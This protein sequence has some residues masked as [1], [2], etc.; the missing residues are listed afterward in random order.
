MGE[1]LSKFST[2][3]LSL[4]PHE[5]EYLISVNKFEDAEKKSILSRIRDNSLRK[6]P[7]DIYDT[8]ID[9]RKYSYVMNWCK[10]RLAEIDVDKIFEKLIHKESQIMNDHIDAESEK[11]LLKLFRTADSSFFSFMKLYDLARI[12]RHFL[13]IRLRHNDFKIVDNFLSKYKARYEKARLTNDKLYS[14]TQSIITQYT[15]QKG[16]TRAYEKWLNSVYKDSTLDGYNRILAWIRIIFIRHNYR[17][18]GGLTTQFRLFD[19]MLKNGAF[20]SRRIIANYHSQ[21]LLYY[22]SINDVE[23]AIYNGYL[24]IREENND[25]LYY[26]NN[27]AALLLKANRVAEAYQ[28]LKNAGLHAKNSQNFH[29]KIGHA[30]YLIL[31]YINMRQYKQAENSAEVF[32]TVY[33]KEIFENR[34]HLFISAYFLAILYRNNY[35][36]ILKLYKQYDIE[37]RDL[38]Y[39][40]G[41]N[42]TPILPWIIAIVNFKEGNLDM[43]DL[44]DKLT[45]IFSEF[46]ERSTKLSESNFGLLKKVLMDFV[47]KLG[48]RFTQLLV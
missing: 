43:S 19:E 36:K 2:Y 48:E 45:E 18:L 31:G 28:I 47:P 14:V 4:F 40:E 35:K 10:E 33:R 22:T 9:R 41:A 34:W 30:S 5:T 1:K 8:T 12:Y 26:V 38:L 17:Q 15:E 32:F 23:N 11:W 24:S 37:R 46:S 21:C 6:N 29:N 44:D 27:L 25:Y 16:E 42:Y 20:Y 39:K 3:A 13:Q 7:V